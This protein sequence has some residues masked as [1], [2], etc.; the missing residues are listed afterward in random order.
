MIPLNCH[1]DELPSHAMTVAIDNVKTKS[2]GG[3]QIIDTYPILM[4]EDEYKAGDDLEL[5]LMFNWA[6]YLK[7]FTLRIYSS[8]NLSIKDILG[9]TNMWHM[10]GQSPSGF[11][12]SQYSVDTTDPRTED[13]VPKS[14]YEVWLASYDLKSFVDLLLKYP[15][16][17]LIWFYHFL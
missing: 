14:L 2:Y 16:N 8:Q 1:F 10:D 13:W 17:I 4:L 5:V 15:W 6:G 11:T 3:F 9:N 12:L 7:D